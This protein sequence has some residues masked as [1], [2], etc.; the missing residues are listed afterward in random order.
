[1][2]LVFNS[3]KEEL[4][5]YCN[6]IL[7][8]TINSCQK[9]KWV[10]QRYLD[11][12]DKENT[13]KFPYYWDEDKA[14]KIVKWF[15]YLRHSKGVLA[16]KPIILNQ[17]QKFI[18][19]NI[20]GWYY[21]ETHYRRFRKG[22]VFVARKNS[23]SQILSGIALYELSA[24]GVNAAEIYTLGIDRGQAKVVFDECKLMLE[25]SPL[26]NKFDFSPKSP[27]I[28]HIKSNSFITA[29]SKDAKKTGEGKNPQL[30][31]I[32]ELH[33]HPDSSMWDVIEKGQI[34]R[35]QPL[36]FGITTAGSSF[37]DENFC[38]RTYNYCSDVINPDLEDIINDSY[39]VMIN[40]MEKDDDIKDQSNWIKA[41][42][43]VATYA[44]G[45]KS[46]E[47][48]LKV[49]LVDKSKMPEVLT[50]NF[51]MWQESSVDTYIELKEW[52]KCRA[53]IT[54]EKFRGKK[55][56]VGIDASSTLD[57][58][59]V[60]FEFVEDVDGNKHY[61]VFSHGFIPNATLTQRINTEKEPYQK[62]IDEGYLTATKTLDGAIIDYHYLLNYINNTVK[63]Y[64]LEVKMI[65]YDKH[66]VGMLISELENNGYNTMEIFQ[67]YRWLNDVTVNFRDMVMIGHVTYAKNGLLDYCVKNA[68]TDMNP[69]NEIMVQK[70]KGKRNKRIDLVASTMCSHKLAMEYVPVVDLNEY[71]KKNG[72]FI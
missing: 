15:S 61:T 66:N 35:S 6:D 28:R 3:V 27:Y 11:D 4:V 30:G 25:G 33:V 5:A 29:L 41:N 36:I 20:Y 64:S 71:I 58:T 47:E 16:S 50:K 31:I 52:K 63:E 43:V 70:P 48:E 69:Y 24:F 68:T 62:W 67:G 8:G 49:A 53:D 39:F 37:D 40:E 26:R 12:L 55:C 60:T 21:N 14:Q 23:K 46:L 7:D 45:I 2:S 44:E 56:F 72:Y 1:M 18:V 42:P 34:A 54:F 57:I 13:N 65:G 19:C 59:G 10:C 51:N 9:H 38:Y 22:L 17:W 32:D